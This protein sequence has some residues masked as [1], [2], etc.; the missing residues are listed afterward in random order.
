MP[1]QPVS[2]YVSRFCGH[3]NTH[4]D[5]K[6]AVFVGDR[7]NYVAAGSDDGNIFIWDRKSGNLVRVLQGDSSIVNCI[8]W[9]PATPTLATSGIE[10]VVKI[11]EPEVQNRLEPEHNEMDTESD[12]PDGLASGPDLVSSGVS[13]NSSRVVSD[14]VSVCKENQ[15]RMGVDPFEVMLMRMGF[16]LQAMTEEG[17]AERQ[18]PTEQHGRGEEAVDGQAEV[19][20]E[21]DARWLNNPTNCRQS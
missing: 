6:E 14:L 4:T 16:R 18:R 9:N 17:G 5:I 8:Q 7:G 12:S 15:H 2:D 19:M 11:W 21:G 13:T 10:N 3:C 1:H 20:E